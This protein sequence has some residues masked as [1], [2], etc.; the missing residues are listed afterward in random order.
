MMF[1]SNYAQHIA[2]EIAEAEGVELD[3]VDVRIEY[4]NDGNMEPVI[5]I[6][7]DGGKF[8]AKLHDGESW[9]DLEWMDA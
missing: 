7:N 9:R 8:T 4:D 2:E 6:R 1:K 3:E 5:T